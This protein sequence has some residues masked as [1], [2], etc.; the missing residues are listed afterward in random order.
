MGCA[1]G[2]LPDL[3]NGQVAVTPVDGQDMRGQ[4]AEEFSASRT[5][6]E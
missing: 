1:N 2:E 5:G 3:T 6:N 4:G